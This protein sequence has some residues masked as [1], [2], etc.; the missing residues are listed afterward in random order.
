MLHPG[1]EIA[2]RLEALGLTQ[3]VFSQQIGKRVS[4]INELIKGK[5]NITLAWDYLLAKFFETEEKYWIYQQIDYDYTLLKKQEAKNNQEQEERRA[6]QV[7]EL[8]G[9]SEN[10]GQEGGIQSIAQ[11]IE[12]SSLVSWAIVGG[13]TQESDLWNE[14]SSREKRELQIVGEEIGECTEEKDLLVQEQWLGISA[15]VDDNIIWEKISYYREKTFEVNPWVVQEKQYQ[16][17]EEGN[18]SLSTRNIA[19]VSKWEQTEE[20]KTEQKIE[21][22]PNK[23]QSREQKFEKL[24]DDF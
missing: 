19:I 3:K 1:K 14:N 5:R 16:Q 9:V 6:Q 22:A 24:F 20:S 7:E 23:Y 11:N 21:K 8:V 2:A 12:G 18:V 15:W 17:S 10:R 4:E 13:N